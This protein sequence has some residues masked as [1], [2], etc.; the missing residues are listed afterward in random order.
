MALMLTLNASAASGVQPHHR[1]HA[2]T[3]QVVVDSAK[4]QT[5]AAMATA[6][7]NGQDE[8]VEAYSDTTSKVTAQKDTIVNFGNDADDWD[9]DFGDSRLDRIIGAVVG[10]T[11][12]VGT[13][14]IMLG[15]ILIILLVIA[16]PII[17]VVLLFRLLVKNHNNKVRLAEKAM[18][19]GQPIPDSVKP[20]NPDTPEYYWRQ[21]VKHVAVG[22]GL[23][24]M[25]CAMNAN[26]LAGI[27]ALVACYGLGQMFISKKSGNKE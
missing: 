25:F 5:P 24:I 4:Q 10:G 13:I 8:G 1:H 21:G 14:L 17:V 20:A 19:T 23:A 11:A 7:G 18:E 9:D 22:V 3:E 27:G 26:E 6:A 15:V 16:A 12:G 2:P